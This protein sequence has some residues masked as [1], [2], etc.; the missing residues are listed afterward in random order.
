MILKRS[1]HRVPGR[2]TERLK[3]WN[4]HILS[5]TEVIYGN[6]QKTQCFIFYDSV[7]GS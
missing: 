5:Y 7:D 3:W 2:P 1:D 6:E 4:G